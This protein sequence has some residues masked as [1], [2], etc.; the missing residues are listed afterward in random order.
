MRWVILVSSSDLYKPMTQRVLG[1]RAADDRRLEELKVG[2]VKVGNEIEDQRPYYSGFFCACLER[3]QYERVLREKKT[4]IGF[5]KNKPEAG[6]S[7]AEQNRLDLH[8][9]PDL[10]SRSGRL[11][12]LTFW[13]YPRRHERLR[14]AYEHHR[15]LARPMLDFER[16]I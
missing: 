3:K 2:L 5:R 9:A 16:V 11:V 6:F 10:S 15:Q 12:A 7:E 4:F 8:I 14:K 1:F 13:T